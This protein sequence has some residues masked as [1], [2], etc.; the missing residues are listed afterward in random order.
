MYSF[1]LKKALPFTLTFVF[2]AALGVVGGLFGSSEKKTEYV[3]STRTYEFRSRCRARPHNLVAETKPLAI[4]HK[5]EAILPAGSGG[6][7]SN[8]EFIAVN[9]TFGADGKVQQVEPPACLAYDCY[10]MR[11]ERS[12]RWEAVERAARL[13]QFTP[14][15]I[16]GVPVTVVK[17]VEIHLAF[18]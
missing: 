1:L 12:G 9:V 18:G 10:D 8:P 16:N 2:G 11:D 17:V 15:T 3:L 14:E 4:L 5:P 6:F 7:K 13:I